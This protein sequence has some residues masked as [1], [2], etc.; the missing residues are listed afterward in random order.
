MDVAVGFEESGVARGMGAELGVGRQALEL[1]LHDG[2]KM[3]ECRG[4]GG[5]IARVTAKDEVVVVEK[6]PSWLFDG[7]PRGD[8]RDWGVRV[9]SPGYGERN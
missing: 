6:D 9:E 1:G 5:G 2:E 7:L 8:C 3:H 4:V